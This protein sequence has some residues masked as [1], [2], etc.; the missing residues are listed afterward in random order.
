[1]QT[2]WQQIDGSWYYFKDNGVMAADELVTGAF[3]YYMGADGR[4]CT[5]WVK[6]NGKWYHMNSNGIMDT[7]WLEDGGSWYF[8]YTEG[9]IATG[10]VTI[11]DKVCIFDANGVWL[12]YAD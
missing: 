10:Q 1:M 3:N 5:G 9:G 12:G 7:G 2:G 6:G 4:M 11:G 8:L